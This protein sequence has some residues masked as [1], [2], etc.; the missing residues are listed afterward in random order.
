[1]TQ[2]LPGAFFGAG[3][4]SFSEFLSVHAPE[5]ASR[6][7]QGAQVGADAVAP[8]GTTVVAVAFGADPAAPEGV[9]MAGDRRATLGNVIAGRD[10][11][12]VFLTDDRSV[13]GV[14]GVAGL[15]I[16]L[17][18]LLVVELEHYEKIEGTALSLS[19]KARRLASMIRG[20][21][22]LALRG[23]PVVP[24]FAGV[25][26]AGVAHIYGY[27]ATGGC[28]EERDHHGIGSG[29]VFARSA[30]KKTWRPGLDETEAVRL[31]VGALF[32]AADDDTATGGPDV[33]RRIWPTVAVVDATGSRML[34][35]DVVAEVV[36]SIVA[37]RAGTD[38]GTE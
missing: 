12:K 36:V 32:D 7:A 27:D 13:I 33:A 19:G 3:T 22:G 14:A 28:Y 38:R 35:P 4:S 16:E 31:A 29:A 21:L 9:V 15:S 5:S 25:D 11:R 30:L 2:R 6:L 23:L 37:E 17:V 24:L 34:H 1:M 20:Q 10:L 8:H 18:R 26:D